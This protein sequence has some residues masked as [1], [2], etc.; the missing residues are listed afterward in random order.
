[1]GASLLHKAADRLGTLQPL[2][3]D[4]FEGYHAVHEEMPRAIDIPHTACPQTVKNPV[5]SNEQSV[6]LVVLDLLELISSQPTTVQQFAK[7]RRWFSE[8]GR[9]QCGQLFVLL[10][11]QQ[12]ILLNPVR[13]LGHRRKRHKT[14]P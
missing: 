11:S 10:W 2:T 5:G 6:P 7:Q 8:L 9:V 1:R 4:E 14:S 12:P 13:Q 3:I